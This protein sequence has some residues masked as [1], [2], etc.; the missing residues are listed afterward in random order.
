MKQKELIKYL[1]ENFEEVTRDEWNND[2]TG[3][4]T[5]KIYTNRNY[6]FKEKYPN[7]LKGTRGHKQTFPIVLEDSGRKIKITKS[8]SI[9]ITDLVNN[10][11]ITFIKGFSLPFL[12]E[13]MK[14]LEDLE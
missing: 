4:K 14:I 13:A 3:K 12:K 2:L 11:K 7:T 1:K 9:I 5:F 10:N 8:Q 6:Y